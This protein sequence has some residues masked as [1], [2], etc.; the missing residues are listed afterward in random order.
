L[1]IREALL[2]WRRRPRPRNDPTLVALPDA[3][4]QADGLARQLRTT[5]HADGMK[6]KKLTGCP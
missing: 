2:A 3:F 6:R 4:N 5:A 1:E